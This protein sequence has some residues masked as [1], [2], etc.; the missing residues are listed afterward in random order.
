VI[1]PDQQAE[2]SGHAAVGLARAA[3][4]DFGDDVGLKSAADAEIDIGER[5]VAALALLVP[6]PT[7]VA[8]QIWRAGQDV[9]QCSDK[10]R[11]RKIIIFSVRES[12]NIIS[13]VIRDQR[14][15][16]PPFNGGLGKSKP[17]PD[18]HSGEGSG[19]ARQER[20]TCPFEAAHCRPKTIASRGQ[21]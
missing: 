17:F 9:G 8:L 6:W 2:P 13:A 15:P 11:A 1:G 4:Q 14:G 20:S 7:D 18:C 3:G 21:I 12:L 19:D 10:H 5:I 16:R